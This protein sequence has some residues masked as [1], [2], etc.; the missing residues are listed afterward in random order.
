[1]PTEIGPTAWSKID[2]AKRQ[3]LRTL[4]MQYF[5]T[6][7]NTPLDVKQYRALQDQILS[8][9]AEFIRSVQAL[10]PKYQFNLSKTGDVE[11]LEKRSSIVK[12]DDNPAWQAYF[13]SV[14]GSEEGSDIDV[15]PPA[16]VGE[17]AVLAKP[18]KKGKQYKSD[19]ADRPDQEKH[20]DPTQG[21]R[22]EELEDVEDIPKADLV[23]E[24]QNLLANVK[25]FKG[26]YEAKLKK[27]F[28]IDIAHYDRIN[29]IT[30]RIRLQS[31]PRTLSARLQVAGL[32][33]NQVE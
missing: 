15:A 12:I 21:A 23:R 26:E 4:Q 24:F 9:H 3:Q 27:E 8:G 13:K 30:L 20:V 25:E 31:G 33:H 17:P 1:M 32:R 28:G 19:V 2:T 22:V 11:I 29:E 14:E 5:G 16:P 10:F 6:P 18:P 7:A